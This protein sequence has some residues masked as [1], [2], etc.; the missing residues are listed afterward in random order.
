M[1]KFTRM[2]FM[3]LRHFWQPLKIDFSGVRFITFMKWPAV[4]RITSGAARVVQKALG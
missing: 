4:N 3:Y 1:K 2:Y